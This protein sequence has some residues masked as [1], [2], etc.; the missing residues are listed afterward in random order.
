MPVKHLQLLAASL[1]LAIPQPPLRLAIQQLL[2][3]HLLPFPRRN[4]IQVAFPLP[5]QLPHLATPL[6]PPPAMPVAI[7]VAFQ[8]LLAVVLAAFPTPLAAELAPNAEAS[9]A[10]DSAVVM[11]ALKSRSEN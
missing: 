1:R 9:D 6:L 11:D 3:P 5:A 8:A 4:A 10:T 7:P 2:Q